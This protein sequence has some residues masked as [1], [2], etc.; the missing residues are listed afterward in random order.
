MKKIFSKGLITITITLVFSACSSTNKELE[1]KIDAESGEVSV[2]EKSTVALWTTNL[3]K[4]QREKLTALRDKMIAET[5]NI[6]QETAKIKGVFFKT[7]FDKRNHSR[8]ADILKDK[9]IKLNKKKMDLMLD[10]FDETK[11]ILGKGEYKE[12]FKQSFQ[13]YFNIH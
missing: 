8:E 2:R 7:L 10:S 6:R 9:L 3:T 1:K 13:S 11:K 12:E 4:T 5:E